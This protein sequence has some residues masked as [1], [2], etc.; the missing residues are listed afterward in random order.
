MSGATGDRN[1]TITELDFAN[2]RDSLKEYLK[3]QDYFKDYDF[4][5]S[6]L[7]TLL[8]VLAYNT[9][10]QSFYANMVANE[11]FI[12]SAV[13]RNSLVSH[14]KQVG[15]T[16]TSYTAPRAVVK[17]E[18]PDYDDSSSGTLLLP[19]YSQFTA[20]GSDG[21]TY[22]FV[23]TSAVLLD[24]SS[25]PFGC[26]AEIYQGAI[27]NRT[28]VVDYTNPD[29]RFVI[30]DI[31]IDTQHMTV[32]VQT[33]TTDTTGFT[34]PW[35]KSG[36]FN[37]ITKTDEVYFLH[38]NVDGFFELTF[39]DNIVG[40]KPA[41]G[42]LI[43]VEYL[44]TDGPL[45]NGIGNKEFYSRPGEGLSGDTFNCQLTN[46]TNTY[47]ESPTNGGS[48][49]ETE[50]SIKYYAPLAYQAQDRAV[51]ALDYKTSIVKAYPSA[52]SISVWGGEDN[53]PPFYGRVFV[54]I[55][56]NEGLTLTESEKESIVTS[57]LKSKNLVT[58]TPIVVDPEY[59]YLK[60]D[61]EVYYEQA[62]TGLQPG[63]L[64]S[65]V[66]RT[67]KNFV[68]DDLEKFDT[69]L[70]FSRFV[71]LIDNT[72]TAITNNYTRI[73]LEKR[74]IPLANLDSY[75]LNYENAILNPHPGHTVPVV[76]STGFP[77]KIG[78]DLNTPEVDESAI[79]T[80]F[81]DDDGNADGN[82][83]G[84][85]RLYYLDGDGNRVHFQNCGTV[86]YLAGKVT[87]KDFLPITE[88]AIE[89]RV[90]VNTTR[91]DIFVSQKNIL[92][93]DNTDPRALV[94]NMVE[95]GRR[96]SFRVTNTDFYASDENR[97]S[98]ITPR[99]T[100]TSSGNVSSNTSSSSSSS[101]GGSSSSSGGGGSSSG[102]GY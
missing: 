81:I 61:S 101:S 67:V 42:N 13:K 91:P 20:Q 78:D 72:N 6:A 32:R 46:N 23:N 9:H 88:P 66:I 22:R 83:I 82:G 65:A 96:D 30:P 52:E 50:E 36:N 76:E 70:K 53:D 98:D 44:V 11:M 60:I 33:S 59:T 74:F 14:A 15:Y 57:I 95:T 55:K 64:Q 12:D 94:V 90:T 75:E 80:A 86:D 1:L 48:L 99:S 29:Q 7:T 102:G 100:S 85:L 27:R 24:T 73:K 10:Y 45:A 17:V 26:T 3:G 28:F 34:D 62:K 21:R 68:N 43:T 58:V 2:L 5:G 97:V 38:E 69:N 54:S 84:N 4:E 71:D 39:G 92:T 77:Y 93:M 51:T 63:D 31:N 35:N 79:V 37:E 89:V 8:D 19:K 87:F 41:D 49:N 25:V 16:P 40:K 18:F 47:V 56:P